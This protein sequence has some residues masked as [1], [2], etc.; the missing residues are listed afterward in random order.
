M[1]NN[2]NITILVDNDSWIIP[3]AKKLEKNLN[4]LGYNTLLVRTAEEIREGWVCFLLGCIHLVSNNYLQR[5]KHN[6]VI[7][8]S[9]LP[10][11]RGFAPM[12]WQILEGENEIPICLLDAAAEA[13]AGDIW[14]KDVISLTGTELC[15]EWRNLQGLKT[16]ELCEK[17][18]KNYNQLTPLSQEGSSTHYPRRTPKDSQLD[19]DKSIKENFNLLRV[20]DNERYPAFFEVNGVKYKLIIVKDDQ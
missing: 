3:Y 10:N 1:S 20:V 7:H 18:V 14:I 4:Q 8:E 16:I 9:D 6:L 17:F 19:I 11:G 5:N 12:A 15:S 2:K 13:D